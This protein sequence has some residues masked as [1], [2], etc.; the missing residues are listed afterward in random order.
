MELQKLGSS[1]N[2]S[3]GIDGITFNV[4][5]LKK[6]LDKTLALLEE[7]MFNPKFTEDAFNTYQKQTL[8]SFKQTKAQPASVASDVFAKINYGPN[9]ILGMSEDGTEYTVKNL[10]LDDI[11][12]YYNNYMT[13]QGVESSDS[14]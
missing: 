10:T 4:Q 11:Q 12:N 13:R 7:R 6:N 2:V 8:E 5:T 3:S 9:N 14:R 1:V